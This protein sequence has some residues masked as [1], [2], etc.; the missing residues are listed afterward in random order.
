MP[1]A[2]SSTAPE[3][4]RRYGQQSF[5]GGK[6]SRADAEIC[7]R[8]E[9]E[10]FSRICLMSGYRFSVMVMLLAGRALTHAVWAARGSGHSLRSEISSDWAIVSASMVRSPS[11]RRSR[12]CR[13]SLRELVDVLCAED[14][15]GI[16]LVLFDEVGLQGS[17]D[18]VHRLE[19]LVDGS[20]SGVSRQPWRQYPARPRVVWSSPVAARPNETRLHSRREWPRS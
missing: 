18:F 20:I 5:G 1:T 14:P 8:A 15:L 19:R 7:R 11:P 3:Q 17:R 9:S 10:Q 12:A 6:G 2:S 4:I 16:C 13:R